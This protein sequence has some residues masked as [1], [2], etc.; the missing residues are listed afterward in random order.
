LSGKKAFLEFIDLLII[1]NKISNAGYHNSTATNQGEIEL[2]KECIL[3]NITENKI[4]NKYDPA[5]PKKDFPKKL[6]K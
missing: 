5:S 6:N 3:I 1:V 2:F 4:P